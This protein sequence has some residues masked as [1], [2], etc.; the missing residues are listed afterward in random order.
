MA[1]AQALTRQI[2]VCLPFLSRRAHR[3]N[4][5]KRVRTEE[6]LNAF[7]LRGSEEAKRET[8]VKNLSEFKAPALENEHTLTKQ[9]MPRCK[10]ERNDRRRV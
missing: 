9:S 10:I 5:E 3:A 4:E 8:E 2:M 1:R 7:T 6:W